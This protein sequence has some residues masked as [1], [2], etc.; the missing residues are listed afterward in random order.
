MKVLDVAD[1]TPIV[2]RWRC[3]STW[4]SLFLM[5]WALSAT[6]QSEREVTLHSAVAKLRQYGRS[7][8]TRVAPDRCA[9]S[10]F[11]KVASERDRLTAQERKEMAPYFQRPSTPG[12][13]PWLTQFPL[14]RKLKT[15]HFVFHYTTRG[16]DAPPV[17]DVLPQN[18]IP[19]YIDLVADAFERSYHFEVEVMGFK[20]PLEDSWG[21]NDEGDPRYDVYMFDA[22]FLG[23]TV[24]EWFDRVLPTAVTASLWFA[25]NSRMYDYFG[26]EEGKRYVETTCAHEF[27]HSSQYAYNAKLPAWIAES[28]STWIESRVY[29]GGRVDDN[30][31]YD[32]PDDPAETDGVDQVYQQIRQWYI[33]PDTALDTSGGHAYGNVIF[34]NYLTE[35]FGMDFVREL[36][37][38]FSDGAG[39]EF[40][41]FWDLLATKGT[42]WVETFK[43]FTVWNYFTADR[44]GLF[45]GYRFASR[46]PP[47]GI[48]PQD[49]H[50]AYPASRL[51]D[52]SAMPE[53]MSSRYVV[54][55][56]PPGGFDGTLS[57]KV[58]GGSVDD[59]IAANGLID[60][61]DGKPDRTFYQRWL[62]IVGLRGWAAP[63]II[64]KANGTVVRDEIFTYHFSQEGQ[65]DIPGFGT[66]VR[67]VVLILVNVRPDTEERGNYISYSAGLK[68]RGKVSNLVA[69][70]GDTG[71]VRLSWQL[72]DLTDTRELY[73]IRKRYSPYDADTDPVN[74]R[75]GRE[76]LQAGD[77]DEN[78]I[79]DAPVNIVARL[80]A[81]TT[82]YTDTTAFNDVLTG[83]T[84]FDPSLIRYYYA[85]VP[86]DHVGLMGEPAIASDGVT[87]IPPAAPAFLV[88]TRE[89]RNGLWNLAV[90]STRPLAEPPTLRVTLPDGSQVTVAVR[91]LSDDLFDAEFAHP[92]YPQ[93]GV[94]RYSLV[95]TSKEGVTGDWI[96]VGGGYQ[97]AP[98]TLKPRVQIVPNRVHRI[99][100]GELEFY[101]RGMKIRVYTFTGEFVRELTLE[102]K[103]DCKNARGETVSNGVYFY[104]AEDGKGFRETGRLVL[105]W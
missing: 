9:S 99:G 102:G 83:A 67:R 82:S 7:A 70:A 75:D 31:N 4:T 21:P 8:S 29:D 76:V 104:V 91:P 40:G 49:V 50:N 51:Y 25:I 79:P 103:W 27:L 36:Y 54:F 64:E 3:A 19:D 68:P 101:P 42:N 59:L 93:P 13:G 98:T 55:E 58:R 74:F 84:N 28:T 32:D 66:D 17:E 23:V 20:R 48:H 44:A 85:V 10:Y 6:A 26:K 41:N 11:Q 53:A 88:S 94:Y 2:R 39:R 97:Y 47:V 35:R 86:V 45:P 33:K 34:I 77:R 61:T 71:G 62:Q 56:P 52:E 87:P 30:D 81:T 90:Q 100:D 57:V 37:E 60:F 22:P 65:L 43:T 18:G 105:T 96:L 89:V 78:S 72:D 5:A 63:V 16:K 73:V 92:F 12:G 69:K 80:P 95:G 46:Y 1:N 38:E 24:S 15:A 14:D